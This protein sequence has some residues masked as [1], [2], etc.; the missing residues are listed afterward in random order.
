MQVAV[1]KLTR[2][3]PVSSRNESNRHLNTWTVKIL[4]SKV[5]LLSVIPNKFYLFLRRNTNIYGPVFDFA[6]LCLLCHGPTLP[7][8]FSCFYS[9][10]VIFVKC[11]Y[12]IADERGLKTHNYFSF[13]HFIRTGN[14]S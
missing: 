2:E 11:I 13:K 1:F 3:Y 8:E 6:S 10:P 4:K 14:G 5:I 9:F 12:E 7:S